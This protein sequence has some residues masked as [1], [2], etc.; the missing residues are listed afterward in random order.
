MN[1][2]RRSYC[3]G[4]PVS[5]LIF[6]S[7]LAGCGRTLVFAE[8]DG[9]NLEI[10]AD[11][12]MSPPFEVNFGLNRA[13]GTIVPPAEQDSNGRP[14]GQAV[15][16]FSGFQV[17]RPGELTPNRVAVE[18]RIVTQFASGEAARNV[19]NR[20]EVAAAIAN[21]QAGINTFV[22]TRDARVDRIIAF[23]VP[24]GSAAARERLNRITSSIT[25]LT[26]AWRTRLANSVGARERL[27]S[28]LARL[29]LPLLDQ[30]A[31]KVPQ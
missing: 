30:I 5:A 4:S 13:V 31:A 8:H 14:A 9:V 12:K 21:V 23:V 24:D 18:L 11:P 2:N 29:P 15:N 10:R 28:E 1:Q 3:L 25:D 7:L 27:Q 19:A 16:M 20:P 6:L 26:D 17:E 22:S